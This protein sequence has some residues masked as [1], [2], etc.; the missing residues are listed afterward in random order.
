VKVGGRT[1]HPPT[2]LVAGARRERRPSIMTGVVQSLAAVRTNARHR[3]WGTTP[4]E[5]AASRALFTPPEE[6]AGD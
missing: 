3:R 5:H 6:S 4:D 2:G 1:P